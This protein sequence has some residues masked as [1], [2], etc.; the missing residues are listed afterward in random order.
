MK[1]HRL[2]LTNYRGVAHRA[3]EFPDRGVVVISGANEIGMERAG[4]PRTA[5]E[6][7]SEAYA[8]GQQ[9]SGGVPDALLPAWEWWR[10]QVAS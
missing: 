6:F 7:V 3:I 2:E 8:R 10:A 9:P 5:L 4:L 1:L